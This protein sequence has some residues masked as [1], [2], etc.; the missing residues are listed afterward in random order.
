MTGRIGRRTPGILRVVVIL[1]VLL[2]AVSVTRQFGDDTKPPGAGP[3]AQG[4]RPTP[5]VTATGAPSTSRTSPAPTEARELS[6]RWEPVADAFIRAYTAKAPTPAA[7]LARL[8]PL[9]SSEVYAGFRY[10]DPGRLPGGTPGPGRAV[11]VDDVAG[12]MRY[13][14]NGGTVWGVDVTVGYGSAATPVVT[15]V[16]PVSGPQDPP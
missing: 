13:P 9:V 10:T 3:A 16:L 6:S 2:I 12:T 15:R 1:A 8:R 4:S 11:V 7:W 5:T 14:L